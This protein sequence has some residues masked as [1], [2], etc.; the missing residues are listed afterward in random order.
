[1]EPTNECSKSVYVDSFVPHTLITVYRGGTTVVGTLHS[2]FGFAAVPLTSASHV[3]D[4]ITATQT[5][6]GVASAHST[7][8]MVVGKMP[9]VLPA[10]TIDPK[11]YACGR[12]VPVHN[13]VS[14]V[15]V[16]VRDLTAGSV[17][18]N[19]STPNLWGSDWEPVGTA[20][21]TIGHKVTATQSACTGVHSPNAAPETVQ[22]DPAPITA[23]TFDTPVVG[24]DAIT[25]HGLYVGSDLRAFEPAPTVIGSGYSTAADN[26]MHVSPSIKSSPAVSAEQDLCSHGS[27]SPPVTPTTTIPPPTLVG[28]ICPG[29]PAAIV[30]DSAINATLVLVK[31]GATVGYGGAAPGDAPVN[32]IPGANVLEN[33]T[34]QVFEYIGALVAAS[35]TT[36]VGCTGTETYHNVSLR[37]GWNRAEN[38]LTPANVATSF[39]LIT[40]VQVDEQI[41]TQPL[42]VPNQTIAGQG[43][44][45]VAYVAIEGNTVYAIDSWSGDILKSTNLGHPVPP[46]LGCTNNGLSV[47]INGTPT[48]D[49]KAQTI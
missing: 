40:T 19:G 14:G 6:N 8:P 44:H 13:L 35:N 18:G 28:P 25:A 23:P 34:V 29:Q 12:V 11:I 49:V 10:P 3:G 5:V 4:Q 37:T 48:I 17:I 33:D 31:S 7:P 42:I 26:W 16:E 32:L 9:V 45:T 21:L 1:V 22:T 39:G 15:T 47:G 20:S 43:I 38:T 30:R 36:V 2:V 41:D 46:L 27:M 24:N